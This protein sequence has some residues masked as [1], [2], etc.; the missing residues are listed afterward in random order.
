MKIFPPGSGVGASVNRG[1]EPRTRLTPPS[2]TY[3]GPRISG[4]FWTNRIYAIG[5]GL[6]PVVLRGALA[7]MVAAERR[8]S[9][10]ADFSL[11]DVWDD[12]QFAMFPDD[13]ANPRAQDGAFAA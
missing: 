12:L 9:G 3:F 4:Y 10:R 6:D 7:D 8:D 5:F 11:A 13:D 2:R 1:T